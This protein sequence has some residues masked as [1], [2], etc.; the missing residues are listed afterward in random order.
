[1]EE[2]KTSLNIPKLSINDVAELYS[3]S[4]YILNDESR[5]SVGPNRLI[6]FL[7]NQELKSINSLH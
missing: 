7:S 1:M 3:L 5:K 6:S 2:L 4:K